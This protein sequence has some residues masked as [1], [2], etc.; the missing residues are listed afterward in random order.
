MYDTPIP[1]E[2]HRALESIGQADIVVG[3]PSYNNVRTIG[4]VVQAA[5]AGLTKYF[6]QFRAVIVNSDGGSSD[7]TRDAV[8]SANVDVSRV[9]IVSTPWSGVHRLSFPYHGKPG[10]KSAFRL[11][12]IWPGLPC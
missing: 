10:K 2:A 1:R 9:Q 12:S 8:L 3:I 6:P 5:Q 7:G 11:V 4:N